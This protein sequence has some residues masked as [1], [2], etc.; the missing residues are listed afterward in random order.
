MLHEIQPKVFDNHFVYQTATDQDLFLSY[1]DDSVLIKEDKDKLWYP[2]FAE[3]FRNNSEPYSRA[4]CLFT[5]DGLRFFLMESVEERPQEGWVYVSTN[6]FRSEP[7][8]WRSFAGVV[9][10]QLNRWYQ[11]RKFCGACGTGLIRSTKERMLQC[12]KCGATNYPTICPSV[13]VGIHDGD[14]LLLTKYAG[15]AYTNFS[16]VAGFVEVGESLEQAVH[17]EVMEEV[18]LTIK[19]LRYYKSQPWPFSDSLLAGFW[20]ELDGDPTITLDE[21]ELSVGIWVKREE[22]PNMDG[23]ISLTGDMIHAFREGRERSEE[24]RQSLGDAGNG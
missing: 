5:I 6:R 12:P 10:W 2:S 9:G 18:G 24:I 14:R 11:N 4:E 13:I 19:N 16:L 7:K 15:R 8:Y 3:Y 1:R 20:A 23:S 21:T 22:L 17:R